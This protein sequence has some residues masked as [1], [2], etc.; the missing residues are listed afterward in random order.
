[1]PGDFVFKH[2]LVRDAAYGTMLSSD[3]RT[4]H[5]FVAEALL[6]STSAAPMPEMLA[7]HWDAAEQWDRAAVGFHAAGRRAIDAGGLHEARSHFEAALDAVTFPFRCSGNGFSI[8]DFILSFA[9]V[10]LA[11]N[12][13]QDLSQ[14]V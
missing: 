4:L 11:L 10:Q 9:G 14:V 2:A 12:K 1:M 6:A 8:H 3:R 5:G 13:C 7:R